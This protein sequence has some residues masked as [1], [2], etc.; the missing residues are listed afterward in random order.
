MVR[1]VFKLLGGKDKL[2]LNP[3]P[4]LRVPRQKLQG[5]EGPQKPCAACSITRSQRR[6]RVAVGG[7][8]MG[9]GAGRWVQ[10]SCGKPRKPLRDGLYIWC[11]VYVYCKLYIYTCVI[12]FIYG[13]YHPF[14]VVLRMVYNWVYHTMG[15]TSILIH[16]MAIWIGKTWGW[17]QIFFRCTLFS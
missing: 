7:L 2:F 13:S 1:E 15:F 17:N 16:F 4:H 12:C 3:S 14:T 9:Q 6:A 11:M 10:K 8:C 5:R